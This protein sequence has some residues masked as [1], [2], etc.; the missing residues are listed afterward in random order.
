[1]V[2]RE[3]VST[4]M[5]QDMDLQVTSEVSLSSGLQLICDAY[6]EDADDDV[7]EAEAASNE[8]IPTRNKTAPEEVRRGSI[9]QSGPAY[10]TLTRE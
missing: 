2:L 6:D 9:W 3:V 8:T 4:V 10:P 5:K 7:N 1:M